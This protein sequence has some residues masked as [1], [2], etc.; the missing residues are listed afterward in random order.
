MVV[1]FYLKGAVK[2]EW[3]PPA[4]EQF[5]LFLTVAAMRSNG[6]FV[7]EDVY[8]VAAEVVA[9]RVNHE[10]EEKPAAVVRGRFATVVS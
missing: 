2:V 5:N 3:R 6:H 8:V 1:S 10:D 9:I 4:P 7:A